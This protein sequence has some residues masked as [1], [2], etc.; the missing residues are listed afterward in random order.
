MAAATVGQR[1][2]GAAKRRDSG[3]IELQ[4]IFVTGQFP[5]STYCRRFCGFGEGEG[6]GRMSGESAQLRAILIAII[7]RLAIPPL[8][9][10]H[11]H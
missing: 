10:L 7:A 8:N 9:Y 6:A 11:A 1:E 3:G 4:Q 2:A 5:E